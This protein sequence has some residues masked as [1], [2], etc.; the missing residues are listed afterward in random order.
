[1]IRKGIDGRKALS[2]PLAVHRNMSLL[3][4]KQCP[5]FPFYLNSFTLAH[6]AFRTACH[7]LVSSVQLILTMSKNRNSIMQSLNWDNVKS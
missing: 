2:E 6:P 5:S 4:S 1:M 7:T 3:F